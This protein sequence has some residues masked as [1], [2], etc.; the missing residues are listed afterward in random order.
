MLY[1]RVDI[2]RFG[3][4]LDVGLLRVSRHI[5]T[6]TSLLPYEFNTFAFESIDVTREFMEAVRPGRKQVQRNAMGPY[7]ICSLSDFC[8]ISRNWLPSEEKSVDFDDKEL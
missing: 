5:Y 4:R 2:S 6:E 3:G 8:L 7:E 1:K